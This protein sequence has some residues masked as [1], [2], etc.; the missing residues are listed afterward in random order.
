MGDF[1]FYCDQKDEKYLEKVKSL[2]N[3][4]SKSDFD[5]FLNLISSLKKYL[6]KTLENE[7]FSTFDEFLNLN[8]IKNNS[9]INLMSFLSDIQVKSN[10]EK[11]NFFK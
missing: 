2:R 5:S 10:K 7:K 3:E 9:F 6:G 1:F 11:E 8:V 4:K